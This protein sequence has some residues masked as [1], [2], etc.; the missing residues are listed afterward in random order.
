MPPLKGAELAELFDQLG[1]GWKVVD[2]HHLEK[3]Y[4]FDDFA[5][6]LDF[7]N[8]VGHIAESEGHHPDIHIFYSKVDL[9]LYTHA[10]L[11]L[12]ENDFIVA[13]KVDTLG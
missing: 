8:K 1:N 4:S 13:A 12:T 3:E 2:E 11:G 5:Q 6:A 9:E 10:V 7:T